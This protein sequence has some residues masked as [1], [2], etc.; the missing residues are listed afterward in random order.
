MLSGL[1]NSAAYD[2]VAGKKYQTIE[3]LRGTTLV[4]SNL[5]QAIC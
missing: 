2:L 3:E 1:G 5:G 4:V